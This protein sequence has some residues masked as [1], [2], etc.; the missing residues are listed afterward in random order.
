MSGHSKWSTIKRKKGALDAKRS[1]VFTK[2]IKEITIAARDG[3]ADS[4]ANPT[5]RVAIQNAKGANMPKDTIER[6]ISK[7]TSGDGAN[8]VE[9]TFEGYAP[10]GIGVYVEATTDN[11]NRTVANVRAVFTKQGGELGTNGSLG[12]MFDRKGVFTISQDQLEGKDIEEFEMEL[13]DGGLE[14]LECEEDVIMAYTSF[15][16]YGSMQKLL[17]NMNI[18]VVSSELQRIPNSTTPLDVESSKKVLKLIDKMEEVDDVNCVYHNLE[19]TSDL[20][21]SLNEE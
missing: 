8:L 9:T 4:D 13:I 19:M 18:D 17:D 21:A 16:D 2:I 12:F 5:L 14:E 10:N 6:A 20:L 1:K 11:N 3:G 15:D 7:G